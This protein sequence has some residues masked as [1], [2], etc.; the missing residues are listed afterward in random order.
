VATVK[1]YQKWAPTG[2]KTWGA[3]SGGVAFWIGVG[4]DVYCNQELPML[5]I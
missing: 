3:V 1:A 2:K 4:K 5:N